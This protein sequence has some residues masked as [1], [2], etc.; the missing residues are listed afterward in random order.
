MRH[1]HVHF[2]YVL[3]KP[4]LLSIVMYNIDIVQ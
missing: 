1:P 3:I 2:S 4:L